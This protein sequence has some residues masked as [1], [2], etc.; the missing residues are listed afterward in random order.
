MT[1]ER[2]RRYFYYINNIGEAPITLERTDRTS[3]DESLV[4]KSPACQ[5]E[6][7]DQ[8]RHSV[9]FVSELF[10]KMEDAAH[11]SSVQQ[12]NN[13][14]NV[15]ATKPRVS[16]VFEKS[17]LIPGTVA[18]DRQPEWQQEVAGSPETLPHRV[19]LMD[20]VLQT[21]DAVFT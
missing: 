2:Q 14:V 6:K 21:D 15:R 13:A 3:V 19:D 1:L 12:P 4:L 5:I 20:E 9:L 16:Q 11:R 18:R 10:L 8:K 7:Q 17:C